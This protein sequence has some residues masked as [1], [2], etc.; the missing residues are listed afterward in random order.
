MKNIKTLNDV[1]IRGKTVFYRSPYDIGTKLENGEYVIKDNS[2]LEATIPTLKY[3]IDNNCKIVIATYVKRPEGKIL[4]EFKTTAHAKALAEL[5]GK[6]VIHLDD[7]VGDQVQNHIT[8]M[9][10]GDMVMLENTRFHPEEDL[11]DPAFAKSLVEK[12]EIIVFDGFPQAHRANAST[13]GI[14]DYL[15]AVIGFYFEQEMNT[16]DKFLKSPKHPLILII[17][18]VKAET[19][20]PVIE[21][22]IGKAD[23]ILIGGRCAID[24]LIEKYRKSPEIKTAKL[25]QDTYDINLES[26]EFFTNI[27]GYSAQIIWAGPLGMFEDPRYSYGTQKI[28]DAVKK[29]TQKGAVSLVAG[30]DTIEALKKF[31]TV[32]DVTYISLAGGA[33]LEYLAGKPIPV[34]EKLL[35]LN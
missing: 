33:T 17:G 34:I 35:S 4:D 12:C 11:N 19:K 20:I 3:L 23:N 30:G 10:D 5:L 16:L 1:D 32:N 24:P 6:E 28:I 8:N 13:T 26:I 31:G 2:R 25:T 27:I 7:C 22:F 14:L 15:P 29:A 18:G 21:N 9:Q